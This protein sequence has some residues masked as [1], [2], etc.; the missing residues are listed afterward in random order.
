MK[1]NFH[2]HLYVSLGSEELMVENMFMAP[3]VSKGIPS[4]SFEVEFTS[5]DEYSTMIVKDIN[6]VFSG[7]DFKYVH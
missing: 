3:V 2:L 1:L 7:N 5:D 6:E 4:S